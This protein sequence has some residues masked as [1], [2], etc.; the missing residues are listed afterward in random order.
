VKCTEFLKELNE[1][2]E[3]SADPRL[4][5]E[6][7]EHMTWCHNCYVVLDTTKKTIQIYKENSVYELPDTVRTKLHDA[8]I[9]KC[10]SSKRE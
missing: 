1:F 8:I 9:A 7:K 10:K 4:M 6:L 5:A 3:G 2:L